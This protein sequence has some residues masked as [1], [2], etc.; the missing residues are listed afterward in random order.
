MDQTGMGE[1]P[2]ED[3]KAAHGETRVEGVLFTAASKL[4]LAIRLKERMKDRSLLIPEG[5]PLLRADL[6][7][8]KSAISPTGIWRLVAEGE[9]DGHADRFWAAAMAVAAAGDRIP[10]YD[11]RPATQSAATARRQSLMYPDRSDDY[12]LRDRD[13]GAL[14]GPARFGAGGW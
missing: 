10:D 6:H 2:I 3:A 4:D 13:G 12:S 11:Y 1:K 14:G 8:I 9:T 5:H 7:E